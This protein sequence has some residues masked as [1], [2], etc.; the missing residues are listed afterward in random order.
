[1]QEIADA[2]KGV[3]I[4]VF[5]K[6]PVNPDLELWIGALERINNAGLKRLGS[7]PPRFQQLRQEVVPQSAAMAYPH[8]VA[9]SHPEPADHLR[10]QPH[11]W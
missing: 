11:R 6:N 4:P 2:L 8:R 10:S 3:D 1:M 9:S 5:V 7:H